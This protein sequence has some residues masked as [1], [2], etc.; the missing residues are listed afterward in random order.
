MREVVFAALAN[1]LMMVVCKMQQNGF[2]RIMVTRKGT[3]I[4][5]AGLK[6]QGISTLK[7]RVP[8][9]NVEHSQFIMSSTTAGL[10]NV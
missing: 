9:P 7:S 10:C 1:G 4:A 8:V 3:A 5:T 6:R 2:W